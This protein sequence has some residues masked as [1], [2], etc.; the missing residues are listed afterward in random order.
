MNCMLVLSAI[1]SVN[2][3][4]VNVFIRRPFPLMNFFPEPSGNLFRRPPEFQFLE[5]IRLECSPNLKKIL[6]V[7]IL[8]PSFSCFLRVDWMVSTDAKTNLYLSHGRLSIG[9]EYIGLGART[10][11]NHCAPVLICHLPYSV[12][13]RPWYWRGFCQGAWQSPGLALRLHANMKSYPAP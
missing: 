4:M 13:S 7:A 5:H 2:G 11:K 1:G 9:A 8:F 3:F 12:L 6:F 10:Y